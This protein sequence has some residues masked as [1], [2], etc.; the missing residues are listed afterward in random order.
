MISAEELHKKYDINGERQIQIRAALEYIDK[1]VQEAAELG[2]YGIMLGQDTMPH[3]NRV[4]DIV[5]RLKTL[6][7]NVDFI[8]YKQAIKINWIKNNDT[9]KSDRRL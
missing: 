2:E 4:D 5:V 3:Y 7:Y 6:G 8:G 1:R 9:T